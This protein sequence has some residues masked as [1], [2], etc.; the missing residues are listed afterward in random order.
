[1][2]HPK[3]LFYLIHPSCMMLVLYGFWQAEA[4]K[5]RFR[6]SQTDRAQPQSGQYVEGPINSR[7][8]LCHYRK[9]EPDQV[10]FD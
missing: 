2:Q 4:Q 5:S 3:N 7:S 9:A 6:E 1:M 8:S 10:M